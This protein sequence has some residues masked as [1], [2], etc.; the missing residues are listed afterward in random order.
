MPDPHARYALRDDRAP[1]GDL[2]RDGFEAEVAASWFVPAVDRKLLKSLMKR[3]DGPALRDHGLW[4]VL[5]IASGTAGVLGWGTWW[6][7]PCFL[8]YG[9]LYSTSDHRAHELAHGTP[10]K[11]RWINEAMYHLN[12]FMTL[13]EGYW[14]RWSHTRH[15][16]HTLIVGKDPEIAVP[17]PANRLHVLLDFFFL[18]SGVIQIAHIC[19]NATGRLVP[20]G[21][22][23][24]PDAE[25]AKVVASSRAYVAV[26]AGVAAACV[27]TGSVLPAMLVVLPRFYGGFMAQ[28]FNITQ[29]AGLA[30]DVYD[31]RLNTRTFH[32][33]PVLRWLYCN[34]N[35][36]IEHH[37][38]PMVPYHRLPELHEAIR[39][40][41]PP[42]YPSVWAAWAEI[43]PALRGQSRDPAVEVNRSLPSA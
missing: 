26:F 35:Y 41:C 27:A 30:E 11:T 6:A 1:D 21:G 31:H 18:R 8:V 24:I 10:Y 42:V 2:R 29:H 28:L 22:H 3:S 43:L 9:V 7:L 16:T 13:H 38:F 23:F 17:R 12:G 40:Q 5:L 4:L 34:M 25:R 39:A 32:A 36:H 15:H 37:G 19:R 33:G 14:W 20:A